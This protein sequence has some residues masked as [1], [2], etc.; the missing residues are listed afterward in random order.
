M[1]TSQ[2][3]NLWP[4]VNLRMG[5]SPHRFTTLKCCRHKEL[6]RSG[7][8]GEPIPNLYARAHT[9]THTRTCEVEVAYRFTTFTSPRKWLQNKDLKV[10]NLS[11]TKVHHLEL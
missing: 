9:R 6:Q 5:G 8:P 1:H 3:V 4:L 10:V 2:V 7:E 11:E